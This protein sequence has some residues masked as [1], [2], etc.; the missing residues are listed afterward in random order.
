MP[1]VEDFFCL[2]QIVVG[3]KT[4]ETY[5]TNHGYRDYD[6]YSNQFRG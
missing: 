5:Y 4:F 1:A 3:K 6:E 2:T